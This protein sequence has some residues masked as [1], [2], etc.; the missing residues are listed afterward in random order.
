LQDLDL[1]EA[2]FSALIQDKAKFVDL[3]LD[4]GV[5]IKQFLTVRR[6]HDLYKIILKDKSTSPSVELLKNL[7]TQVR[8]CVIIIFILS[9]CLIFTFAVL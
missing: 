3:F 8:V 2:M 9:H 5:D 4:S 7:L 1:N 6:L